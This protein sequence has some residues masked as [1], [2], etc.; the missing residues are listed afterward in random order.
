MRTVLIT[1]GAGFI[2]SHTADRLI[3][4]GYH[5]RILDN[6]SKPK[7]MHGKPKYLSP[8]AEFVEADVRDKDALKNALQ[9]ASVVYHL[10]AYQDYFQDL[11]TFF[12]V[13]VVSTASIYELIINENLPIEKVV[14]AS[15][16]FVHGEGLYKDEDGKTVSPEMRGDDQLARGQ[17]D[18]IDERGRP[19]A[20]LPTPESHASPPNAYAIS[21]YSQELQALKFGRRYKIPSVALRY[22]IVQGARQS[23]YSMYSGACRIFS[24][25]YFFGRQPKIYEDGEQIRDF[26]NIHDVV[27]ANIL[28]LDDSRA[29]YQS[30]C[31]GG[32][33]PYMVKEFD[34]IV[35]R[36]FEKEHLEPRIPGEYR[37]G[38]NRHSCSAI[39]KLEALGWCPKRSAEDSVRE[40]REYIES[41][42]NIEG[43]LEYAETHLAASNVVRKVT[44]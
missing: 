11:S 43:V 26:V 39:S 31:V 12:D 13:N 23:L 9:G 2:G 19:L 41:H 16:Q 37:V 10:A 22:S 35:A 36:V 6:L 21:K 29:D 40:Y 4:A 14:V 18:L 33:H 34:R 32:G 42:D 5:V 28:V 3:A 7:H 24:L 8:D 25:S 38:D 17:W 30:F 20:W 1:G 44:T 15:S 27:D